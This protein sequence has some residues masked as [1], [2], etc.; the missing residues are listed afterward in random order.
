M[1][2]ERARPNLHGTRAAP[3]KGEVDGRVPGVVSLIDCRD[4]PL[5]RLIVSDSLLTP[6]RRD[7]GFWSGWRSR[8]WLGALS[9][10]QQAAGNDKGV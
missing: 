2:R 1:I 8:F 10:R 4:V 9:S 6:A 5:C 7:A 3:S